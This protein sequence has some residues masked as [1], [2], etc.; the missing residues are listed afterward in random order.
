MLVKVFG[1][2][3]QGIDAIPVTIEARADAGI[4]FTVVGLPDASV[5]ES[6]ERVLSSLKQYGYD[7]PRRKIVINMAPADVRK[8]GAAYDLPLA[9]A[10]LSA[11]ERIPADN[12]GRY[13]LMGELSLDGSL[14]PVRGIL[15][16]AV[17]ARSAGFKGMIVPEGNAT[18][19]AVVNRLN[20][21]GVRNLAE[22]I[23]VITEAPDAV[24]PTVVD[25]RA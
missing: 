20:V 1:A 8:E 14:C 11:T 24:A 21:L 16:M 10:I 22:A 3:V 6:Q 15:P 17:M 7:V 25:T 18:E 19:A 4:G 12:L 2:A 13:L 9:V 23:D 5:K